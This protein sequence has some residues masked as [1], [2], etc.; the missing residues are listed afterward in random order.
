MCMYTEEELKTE[1]CA[2]LCS[3]V[4]LKDVDD[5][6]KDEKVLVFMS[7]RNSTQSGKKKRCANE[8]YCF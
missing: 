8:F 3:P 6:Q 2:C 1:M 7:G 4:G 5:S